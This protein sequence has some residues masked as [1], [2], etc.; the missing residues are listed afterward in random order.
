MHATTIAA[1]QSASVPEDIHAN[2]TR[3]LV[4]ARAAAAHG[5]SF[6]L[7]PELSL[8]G[9]E[10]PA[11]ARLALQADAAVLDPLRA[12]AQAAS[13]TIVV[14]AP[15]VSG[16]G[17]PC[18]GS[19]ACLPDGTTRTYAKRFL[20]DGENAFASPGSVNAEALDLNDQRLALAI[21]A[22]TVN[23]D[24]PRWAHEAGATVY[25]AGVLW[26]QQGHGVDAE[27]VQGHCARHGF[28]ALVANHAA[29]T[30][31]YQAA[32][33]SAFWGPGGHLLCMAPPNEST[34]LL[35]RHHGG[36][37][38]CGCHPVDAPRPAGI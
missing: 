20:H 11:L 28:A 26:S 27:L 12:L 16:H 30:G 14:G 2:L 6:L 36:T 9:Y 25:A 7:F 1:A 5:V 38:T 31:G 37:W 24:H 23:P 22:D 34:L 21:C 3:H 10:L 35:A 29:P 19:V 13:M 15:L 17:K 4:F 33:K 32:G 18:I 8:T